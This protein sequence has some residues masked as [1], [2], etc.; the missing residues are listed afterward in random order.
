MFLA[1]Y[2]QMCLLPVVVLLGMSLTQTLEY[3]ELQLVV[4]V[5]RCAYART[6]LDKRPSTNVVMAE[7]GSQDSTIVGANHKNSIKCFP[8]VSLP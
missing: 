7:I 5:F 4:L 3:V 6:I 2:K 1:K 8:A